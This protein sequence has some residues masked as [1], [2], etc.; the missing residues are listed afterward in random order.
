MSI[1][2]QG[3]RY[4]ALLTFWK[5]LLRPISDKGWSRRRER[6]DLGDGCQRLNDLL[7]ANYRGPRRYF[8]ILTPMYP[9]LLTCMSQLIRI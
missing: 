5:H 9:L 2:G 8:R 7:L 1:W 4:E 3:E 6:H